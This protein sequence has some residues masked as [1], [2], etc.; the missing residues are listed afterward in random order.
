MNAK[1]LQA[2][3]FQAFVEGLIQDY[4]VIAP[5]DELAYGR[6]QSWE[7]MVWGT[8]SPRQSLK[9]FYFPQREV[10]VNYCLE[11]GNVTLTEPDVEIAERVILARPCD[12]AAFPV[13]DKVFGWDYLDASYLKRR[14]RTTI[15]AMACDQPDEACFC[16]SVGGS[17]AGTEGADLLLSPLGDVY[18]V[19]IITDRGAALVE[20]FADLFAASDEAQDSRCAQLQDEWRE[21]VFG[22]LDVQN[23]AEQLDFENPIWQGITE[24]CIDCSVCTF[25]CPTCHCFDIQDEGGPDG[26]ERVRLWDSCASRLFT[27]TAVHQP[28]PT[29]SSRY[30]QR[31]LHKFQYYPKNFGRVLCVGCGRC[32]RHCPVG[33]D[34][35]DVLERVNV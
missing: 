25:L 34:I 20:R 27:K 28:R 22:A 19:Q 3:K 29:H 32:A 9:E 12:A 4:E 21:K 6:I 14:Q 15:I 11:D 17:P 13:L 10:L 35:T 24:Q 30:R 1:I 7:Q 16:V 8:K 31:I 2:D 23:L 5:R 26:G 18:H 33:I